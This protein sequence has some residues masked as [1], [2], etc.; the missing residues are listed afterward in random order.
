MITIC[1][2]QIVLSIL[3][4]YGSARERAVRFW[5]VYL[6]GVMPPEG[7]RQ[8]DILLGSERDA[9]YYS[10]YAQNIIKERLRNHRALK[11]YPGYR[12]TDKEA[13]EQ[14]VNGCWMDLTNKRQ[15]IALIC[16][17]L[18]LIVMPF[19]GGYLYHLVFSISLLAVA[20]TIMILMRNAAPP[21]HENWRKVFA[22]HLIRTSKEKGQD[23]ARRLA[24]LNGDIQPLMDCYRPDSMMTED[25]YSGQLGEIINLGRKMPPS[26]QEVWQTSSEDPDD[27][28]RP[29]K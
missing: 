16:A 4:G 12:L 28:W 3:A 18:V 13:V 27:R 22:Q 8:K 1:I 9:R 7:A 19:L 10:Q 6:N 17:P 23:I 29:P 20:V 15:V 21:M 25:D 14:V 24:F 11:D 26:S 5:A 2:V